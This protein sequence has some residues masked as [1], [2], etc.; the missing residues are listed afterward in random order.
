MNRPEKEAQVQQLRD[1]I[2]ASSVVLL[3]SC[4]GVDVLT[5]TAWKQ[6]FRKAGCEYKVFKNTLIR[7][8]I[9]GTGV[10]GA[11]VH[12]EGPTAVVFGPE[13][14]AAPAKL[15]R[16]FSKEKKGFF[17]KGGWFDGALLDAKMADA[18]ADMPSVDQIKAQLLSTLMAPA[19]QLV[20][21]LNAGAQ[22]FVYLLEAK[23]EKNQ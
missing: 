1:K 18:L 21:V 22:E 7:H 23:K 19:T 6:A 13:H 15:I 14:P 2:Q 16:D 12:L 20:R 9:E 4:S 3:C 17:V 10:A 5:I 8:A 11:A